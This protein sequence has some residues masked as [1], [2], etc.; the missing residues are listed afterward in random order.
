[1][2]YSFEIKDE[3]DIKTDGINKLAPNLMSK[4]NYGVHYK[5]LPYYLSQGIQYLM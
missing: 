2:K 4:K 3:Y 5:S 1:M